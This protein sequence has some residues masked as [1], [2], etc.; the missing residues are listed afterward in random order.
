MAQVVKSYLTESGAAQRRLQ[1]RAN[2][3]A[4]GGQ[5]SFGEVR[6]A[7]GYGVTH[8]WVMVYNAGHDSLGDFQRVREQGSLDSFVCLR[9]GACL[10]LEHH[11]SPQPVLRLLFSVLRPQKFP[12]AAVIKTSHGPFLGTLIRL[13]VCGEGAL[14]V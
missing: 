7:L 6:P 8:W 2:I 5:N 11:R 12:G 13:D 9:F 4:D 14:K 3:A 10:C 1:F